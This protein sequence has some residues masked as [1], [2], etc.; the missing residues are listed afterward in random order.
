MVSAT[1]CWPN[2]GMAEAMLAEAADIDTATVRDVVHQE[3]AGDGQT[4][5]GSEVLGDHL[6]VAATAGVGLHILP[7]G[8]DHDQHDGNDAEGNPRRV[9]EERQP[10]QRQNQQDLL[11]A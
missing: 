5:I 7:V 3:R 9:G 6:V 4:R 8:R 1:R 2:Q 10:A 11:V